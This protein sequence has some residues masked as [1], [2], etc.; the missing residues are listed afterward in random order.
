MLVVNASLEMKT[1]AAAEKGRSCLFRGPL[2]HH[3]DPPS[4]AVELELEA[5]HAIV[6]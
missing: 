6:E 2:K 5:M 4:Q 3:A 1:D